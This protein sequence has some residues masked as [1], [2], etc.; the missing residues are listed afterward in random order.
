MGSQIP[1]ANSEPGY[2]TQTSQAVEETES[3]VLDPPTL[4][5]VD[6][7]G[8]RVHHNIQIRAYVQPIELKVI[9]S[10]AHDQKIPSRNDSAK[11][12]KEFRRAH[13]TCQRHRNRHD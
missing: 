6:D 2:K 12:A 4:G 8:Q 3:I 5:F 13:T 9:T 10:I 7:P 11:A 1:V